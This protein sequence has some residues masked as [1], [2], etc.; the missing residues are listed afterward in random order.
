MNSQKLLKYG[1]LQITVFQV[2]KREKRVKGGK[3]GE[4]ERKEKEKNNEKKKKK[5][6]RNKEK[7]KKRDQTLLHIHNLF[8]IKHLLRNSINNLINNHSIVDFP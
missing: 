5:K 1:K 4:R 6:R 8:S 7:N 3:E 2:I